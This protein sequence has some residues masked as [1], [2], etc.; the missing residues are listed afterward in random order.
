MFLFFHSFLFFP[1]EPREVDLVKVKKKK[2][3]WLRRSLDLVAETEKIVAARFI[4]QNPREI[5]ANFYLQKNGRRI[6][7]LNEISA[8]ATTK[9]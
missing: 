7:N 9:F 5:V 8:L 2:H 3:G 6:R 1:F 4:P